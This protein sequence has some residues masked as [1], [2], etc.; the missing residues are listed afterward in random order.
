MTAEMANNV[1]TPEMGYESAINQ[2]GM[3][4]VWWA[5]ALGACLGGNG[6]LVGASAN[7]VAIGMAEKAGV[8]ISFSKFLIYG[9]PVMM[10]TLAISMLYIWLRYYYL[11]I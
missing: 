2:P 5:M 1:F 9:I 11:H 4:P 7:V 8:S 3:M 6:S 10:M